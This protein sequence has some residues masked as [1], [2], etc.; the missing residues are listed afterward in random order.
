MRVRSRQ[1]RKELV[2]VGRHVF[3]LAGSLLDQFLSSLFV[4]RCLNFLKDHLLLGLISQLIK[5]RFVHRL[6]FLGLVD[7]R[8]L[9]L[10]L[11]L[12]K[13]GRLDQLD[14]LRLLVGVS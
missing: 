7:G 12:R 4:N 10:S 9:R 11:A 1:Q 6:T 2:L 8:I 3:L 13:L 14:W 5:H